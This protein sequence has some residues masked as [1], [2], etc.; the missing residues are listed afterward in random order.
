ML[1]RS[2]GIYAP[3]KMFGILNLD[4]EAVSVSFHSVSPLYH[5]SPDMLCPIDHHDVFKWISQYFVVVCVASH[6][7]ITITNAP[8]LA[9]YSSCV[10]A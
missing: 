10:N 1:H 4:S 9:R 5:S 6:A 8:W 3:H 2:G 7:A